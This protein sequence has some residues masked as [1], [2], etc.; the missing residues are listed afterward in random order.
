MLVGVVDSRGKKINLIRI[1]QIIVYGLLVCCGSGEQ[2]DIA[3]KEKKN[4]ED[5]ISEKS[6]S[7]QF[8]PGPIMICANRF[9]NTYGALPVSEIPDGAIAWYP[10]GVETQKVAWCIRQGI[11]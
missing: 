8:F 5:F 1:A 4:I 9:A 6:P 10:D 2:V 11:L 7:P 3:P